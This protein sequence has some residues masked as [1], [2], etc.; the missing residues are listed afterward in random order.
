MKDLEFAKMIEKVGKVTL[1]GGIFGKATLAVIV[2]CLCISSITLAARS[3][4]LD[5][6]AIVFI[7]AIGTYFLRRLLQFAEQNQ[8]IA[9]IEG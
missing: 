5:A 8:L 1:R 7:I 4:Y 3:I 6:V 9:I 2:I